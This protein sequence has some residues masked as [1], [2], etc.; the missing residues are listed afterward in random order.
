MEGLSGHALHTL[1]GSIATLNR[2]DNDFEIKLDLATCHWVFSHTL[3]SPYPQKACSTSFSL[4][5]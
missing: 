4:L 5:S 1:T 2:D 3:S